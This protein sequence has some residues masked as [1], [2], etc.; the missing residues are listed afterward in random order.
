MQKGFD[1]K[2][3]HPPATTDKN[4]RGRLRTPPSPGRRRGVCVT[5]PPN[6]LALV[7]REDG[8]G[9]LD[10]AVDL[11]AVFPVRFLNPIGSK[12]RCRLAV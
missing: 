5:P 7:D 6:H 9:L 3:T 11:L 4:G 10:K 12:S 8:A 2:A 1:C